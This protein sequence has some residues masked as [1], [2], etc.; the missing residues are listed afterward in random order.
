ME[1]L[2]TGFYDDN[3]IGIYFGDVIR[4]EGID[5]TVGSEAGEAVGYAISPRDDGSYANVPY[6]LDN[7]EGW[8]IIEVTEIGD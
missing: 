3:G 2:F 8:V 1:K 5:V 7:G 4:K 6:E